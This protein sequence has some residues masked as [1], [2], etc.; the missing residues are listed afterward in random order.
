MKSFG[1]NQVKFSKNFENLYFWSK[2]PYFMENPYD[3][4][5]FVYVRITVD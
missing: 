3:L 2:N 5:K 4:E 1:G